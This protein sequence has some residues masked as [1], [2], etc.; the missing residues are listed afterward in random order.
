VKENWVKIEVVAA[1][2]LEYVTLRD[3]WDIIIDAVNEGE[4]WRVVY[5]KYLT[6][7]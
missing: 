4:D 6:R 2:L 1:A 5:E 7:L 3:G